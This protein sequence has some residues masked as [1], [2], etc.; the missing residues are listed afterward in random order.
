MIPGQRW[1]IRAL[2]FDL[3]RNGLDYH[4]RLAGDFVA[5]LPYTPIYAH[6]GPG[7][8][9]HRPDELLADPLRSCVGVVIDPWADARAVYATMLLADDAVGV[10]R[11][12]L[13]LER[14]DRLSVLGLS[15]V[16][17]VQYQPSDGMGRTIRRVVAVSAVESLDLV[18]SPAA[19]GRVLRSLP[20]DQ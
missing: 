7:G 17:R 14:R 8:F 9:V 5:T 19:G 12:L 4:P 10:R 3:S 2:R 20:A 11:A 18:T 1:A 13:E 15:I 16:A 6:R